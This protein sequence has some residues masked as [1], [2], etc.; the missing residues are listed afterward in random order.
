MPNQIVSIDNVI[1][2][3]SAG[4]IYTA[5]ANTQAVIQKLIA[6]SQ[7]TASNRLLTIY[8]VPPAGTPGTTNIIIDKLSVPPG[9][10]TD[11]P[12]LVNQVL[13]AGYTLQAL[14]D[15][16]TTVYLNGSLIQVT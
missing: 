2:P 7:E 1:A 10:A 3:T 15:S 9:P 13:E 8:K 12:Q 5:P 14:I 11:I 6:T 4:I 16:G